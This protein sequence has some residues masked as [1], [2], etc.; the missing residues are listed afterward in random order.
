MVYHFLCFSELVEYIKP[1]HITVSAHY[2]SPMVFRC[3][4]S[5][6]SFENPFVS[7]EVY[8]MTSEKFAT[9]WI[10]NFTIIQSN[11]CR[12][13]VTTSKFDLYSWDI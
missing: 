1:K 7:Y 12:C 5:Y 4:E 2:F 9:F 3:N 6:Q 13:A 8:L 10:I 11:A